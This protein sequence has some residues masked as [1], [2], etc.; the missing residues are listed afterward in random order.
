MYAEH[1]LG[2]GKSTWA[3]EKDV[4]DHTKLDRRKEL[5]GKTVVLVGLD[6]PLA[7]GGN[8]SRGPISTLGQLV[9]VRGET[10]KDESETADQWQPEWN[11]NQA[12]LATAIQTPGRAAGPQEGTEA[13]SWILGV[14]E[15]SQGQGCYWLQRDDGWR[16]CEKRDYGEKCLWRKAR[17]PWKQGDTAESCIGGGVITTASLPPHASIRS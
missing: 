1:Q 10:F 9:W 17:Q 5:G 11:E 15:Q 16:G 4:Q 8:W 2:A 14:A 7:G 3:E 13:G 6:L 12:V